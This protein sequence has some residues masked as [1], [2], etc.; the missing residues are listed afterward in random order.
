[1]RC[2]RLIE[3]WRG[4]EKLCEFQ[5]SY[6]SLSEVIIVW[7]QLERKGEGQGRL[8]KVWKG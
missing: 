5:R 8:S 1:M 2:Q 6:V 3:V 7:V 4:S